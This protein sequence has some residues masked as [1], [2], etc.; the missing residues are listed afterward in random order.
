MKKCLVIG[1]GFAGLT[2]STYL[3]NTGFNVELIE[4]TPKLGGRVYSFIH[5]K[6]NRLIDNGQHIMMGCYNETLKFLK[7][8]NAL[9]KIEI[10]EKLNVK[11]LKPGFEI[12]ELKSPSFFYPLNLLAA[13]LSYTAISIQ[14]RIS[15]LRLFLKLPI[16]SNRDLEK[17]SVEELLISENQN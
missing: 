11:F 12:H 7:L 8:I 4:A 6:T 10:Q 5:K 17:M 3:S 2:A 9:D 15:I 1:G 16:M 13:I 14:E